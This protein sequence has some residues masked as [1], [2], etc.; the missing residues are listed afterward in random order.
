MLY[1]I[2]KWFGKKLDR[3]ITHASRLDVHRSAMRLGPSKIKEDHRRLLKYWAV[4]KLC[5]R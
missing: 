2:K 5:V 3:M 1:C 4:D